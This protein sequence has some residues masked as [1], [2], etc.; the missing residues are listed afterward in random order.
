MSLDSIDGPLSLSLSLSKGERVPSGRER[1][2][3][4]STRD[5]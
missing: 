2:T 4:G 1:G 5:P 3:K